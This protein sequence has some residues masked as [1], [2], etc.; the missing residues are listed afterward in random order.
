MFYKQNHMSEPITRIF[1]VIMS[2]D[3]FDQDIFD[4][5][6][7]RGISEDEFVYQL[8]S[9]LSSDKL[10][11]IYKISVCQRTRDE[12]DDIE[13]WLMARMGKFFF[14]TDVNCDD[15]TAHWNQL[16]TLL[17]MRTNSSSRQ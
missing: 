16:R 14:N 7:A 6:V 15:D 3:D 8:L 17:N 4:T 2:F 9:G 12:N 10:A 13:P 11:C 5:T 1:D